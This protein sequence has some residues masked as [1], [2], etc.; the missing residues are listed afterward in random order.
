MA[1]IVLDEDLKEEIKEEIKQ[2]LLN[3]NVEE[4]VIE[5]KTDDTENVVETK[6]EE[7]AD[8]K[9]ACDEDKR[10]DIDEIG[11]ILKDKVDEEVL[12]T[13]LGL[14]EKIAYNPSETGANDEKTCDEDTSKEDDKKDDAVSMDEAI[15]YL[16]KRDSLISQLK[17]VIGENA[18]YNS[19]SIPEVVVYACDKLDIKPSLKG[20]EGYLQAVSRQNKVVATVA[21]DNAIAF[22]T[23][24]AVEKRYDDLNK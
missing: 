23:K 21:A 10:K 17:P 7:D 15:K 14:V 12:R 16:A 18:N 5:E 24:S 13:V 2:E 3:G 9:A 20:L 19:M 11:G 4:T 8:E 1:K 22:N 6:V